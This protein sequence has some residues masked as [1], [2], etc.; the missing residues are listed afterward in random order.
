MGGEGKVD[1]GLGFPSLSAGSLSMAP[2][3]IIL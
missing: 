3:K 1:N 2:H